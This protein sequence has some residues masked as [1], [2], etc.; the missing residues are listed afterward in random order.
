[1]L[2]EE[3]EMKNETKI[4]NWL[5]DR[6][7]LNVTLTYSANSLKKLN[8]KLFRKY[9]NFEIDGSEPIMNS[10]DN[11]EEELF[12]FAKKHRR[13]DE[14]KVI[15]ITGILLSLLAAFF[16]TLGLVFENNNIK[17]VAVGIDIA[18][19]IISIVRYVISELNFKVTRLELLESIIEFRNRKLKNKNE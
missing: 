5:G 1:M 16:I 12:K 14:G 3:L 19:I 8:W 17:Y 18:V 4:R 7:H 6:Y 15:G 9:Q 10:D 13:Y 11:T 2:K